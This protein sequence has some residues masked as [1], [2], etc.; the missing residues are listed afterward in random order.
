MISEQLL[1]PCS[2]L[3]TTR[4]WHR[5]TLAEG[6]D[7]TDADEDELYDAMDW[8]LGMQKLLE[9]SWRLVIFQKGSC[10]L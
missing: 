7:V 6:L 1:N 10:F 8:L 4:L 3:A 9:K 2:K 5:T